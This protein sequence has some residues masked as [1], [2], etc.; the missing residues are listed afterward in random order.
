MSFAIKS[1]FVLGLSFFCALNIRAGEN[2][3]NYFR[4]L[5]GHQYN[6]IG[7][8]EKELKELNNYFLSHKMHQAYFNSIY[9]IVTNGI[10]TQIDSGDFERPDCIGKMVVS[11]SK[12]YRDALF[13]YY[14]GQKNDTPMAWQQAFIANDSTRAKPTV[15]IM[16]GMNAHIIHDLSET[17]DQVAKADFSCN[18]ELV[19]D[20]YF[21]LNQFFDHII[22]ILNDDLYKTYSLLQADKNKLNLKPIKVEMVKIMVHEMRSKAWD[23]ANLLSESRDNGEYSDNLLLIEKE[24]GSNAQATLAMSF[25]FP[26]NGL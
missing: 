19:H 17:V 14:F 1:F 20:D 9:T 15:Q 4:E 6:S 25:L 7:D 24:S 22:E 2:G 10:R 5:L 3:T 13:S 26:R 23:F 18:L 16:L 21:K 11:F 8:V 12:M